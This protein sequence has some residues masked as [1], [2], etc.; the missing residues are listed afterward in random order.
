MPSIHAPSPEQD[1]LSA[2]PNTPQHKPQRDR[3]TCLGSTCL[4]WS[5]DGEL[6]AQDRDT[7]LQRLAAADT[8]LASTLQDHT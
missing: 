5:Q 4:K 3:S 8:N 7:L 1:N 6:S 2:N